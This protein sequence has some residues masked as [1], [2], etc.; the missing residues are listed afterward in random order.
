M[1]LIYPCQCAPYNFLSSSHRIGANLQENSP[2]DTAVFDD[3]AGLWTLTIEG[4][5]RTYKARVS[6]AE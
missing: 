1:R 3:G 2:V 5:D 4:S 6:M